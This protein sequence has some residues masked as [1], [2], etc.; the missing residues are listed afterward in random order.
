MQQNDPH[1]HNTNGIRLFS[2]LW[3]SAAA[4]SAI[5]VLRS[6]SGFPTWHGFPNTA[7]T[8]LLLLAGTAGTN[9]GVPSRYR[10]SIV[11]G[12]G[13][14]VVSDSVLAFQRF[15]HPLEWGR[16]LVLGTYFAAQGGIALSVMLPRDRTA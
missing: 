16:I 8:T 13:L 2:L 11:T 15:C 6:P 12:A 4:V 9:G 1:R 5:W 10:W 3:L 7:S 14:F